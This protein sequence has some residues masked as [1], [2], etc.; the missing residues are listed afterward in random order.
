MLNYKFKVTGDSLLHDAVL[1]NKIRCIKTLLAFNADIRVKNKNGQTP[2]TYA[3]INDNLDALRLNLQ[4]GFRIDESCNMK[5]EIP[6]IIAA[7]MGSL[8]AFDHLLYLSNIQKNRSEFWQNIYS[9]ALYNA[10]LC[11]QCNNDYTQLQKKN[12]ENNYYII[13]D[14]L[15]N[16][17][18]NPNKTYGANRD[19]CLY[20][21][22][23]GNHL[24]IVQ[25]LVLNGAEVNMQNLH[26]ISPLAQSLFL[27][28]FAI[29]EFLESHGARI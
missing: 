10:A 4:Y 29:S 13:I 19:N 12:I 5:G 3:I 20:P 18:A 7:R 21:A 28:N 1:E 26:G 6:L 24:S 8:H 22:I 9:I 17:H 25:I 23:N 16:R 15:L 27:H 11:V 2:I 14:K